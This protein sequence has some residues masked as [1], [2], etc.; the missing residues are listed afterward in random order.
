MGP[1]VQVETPIF[2]LT[3]EVSVYIMPLICSLQ[4][5][6]RSAPVNVN[7]IGTFHSTIKKYNVSG[8][9]PHIHSKSIHYN[10]DGSGRDSYIM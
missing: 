9:R 5:V 10:Q 8:N 4:L 7:I 2:T 1:M 6:I 3:M